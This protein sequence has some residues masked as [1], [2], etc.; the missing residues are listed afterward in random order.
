LPHANQADFDRLPD[1]VK[2]GVSVSFVKHYQDVAKLV[3]GV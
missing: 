3:L 1:Y 2:A